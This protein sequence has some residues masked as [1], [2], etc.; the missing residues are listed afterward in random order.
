MEESR[1]LAGSLGLAGAGSCLLL[2]SK[3]LTFQKLMHHVCKSLQKFK[4]NVDK[5]RG[6]KQTL[7]NSSNL[8]RLPGIFVGESDALI[9]TFRDF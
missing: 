5:I 9:A 7:R 8:Q 4:R 1:G 3:I 6:T 2:S